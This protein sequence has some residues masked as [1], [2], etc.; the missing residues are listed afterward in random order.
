MY[1][2]Q[3]L[4]RASVRTW[5]RFADKEQA[6]WALWAPL[7]GDTSMYADEAFIQMAAD[8]Y[9]V[10]VVVYKVD[11]RGKELGT[12]TFSPFAGG[13]EAEVRVAN[14]VQC[15]YVAV[16]PE[17][18]GPR[19]EH[20]PT[21]AAWEATGKERG[22]MRTREVRSRRRNGTRKRRRVEE[23]SIV[24][25]KIKMRKVTCKARVYH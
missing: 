17:S 12:I 7:M 13:A 9:K 8:Y 4:W 24:G 6:T 2:W 22:E 5:E 20:L 18:D 15:H 1:R 23:W 25:T 16:L 10:D 14:H 3:R 11:G 21:P 19:V